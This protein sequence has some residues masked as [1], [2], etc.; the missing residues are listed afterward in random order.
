MSERERRRRVIECLRLD[1]SGAAD[2]LAGAREVYPGDGALHHVIDM[3]FASTET[4]RQAL[5]ELEVAARLDPESAE[6]LADLAQVY[7]A[8]AGVGSE[9]SYSSHRPRSAV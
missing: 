4:L 7:L 5:D 3:A 6:I 9:S 1:T 2:E 8:A